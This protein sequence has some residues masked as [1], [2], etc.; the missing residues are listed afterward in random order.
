MIMLEFVK[1]IGKC[2]YANIKVTIWGFFSIFVNP[3]A[4]LAEALRMRE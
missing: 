1:D 2:I 4:A 3:D